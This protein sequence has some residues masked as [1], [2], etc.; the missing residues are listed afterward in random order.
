MT[1][2][3]VDY[4]PHARGVFTPLERMYVER[5][6]KA[7]FVALH[8]LHYK[9]EARPIAPHFYRLM[10]AGENGAEAQ[11]IGVMVLAIPRPL[12]KERHKAFP[13]LKPVS[14]SRLT[15][16]LHYQMINQHFRVVSRLVIDT[17]YRGVGVSY[18]FQNLASRM[19]GFRLLEIQSAMSK[20]NLFAQKA[21]FRFVKPM[22][23]NTYDK[24]VRFFRE[25]FES[26]PADTEALLAEIEAL[27]PPLREHRVK[28]LKTFYYGNSS[29]EKTG[30][31]RDTGAGRVAA[32]STREVL[33]QAQQLV[34]GSPLYGVYQNPDHGRVDIPARL[35]LLDF[36]RQKTSERLKT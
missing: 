28:E 23:S 17:M 29:I 30:A 18:R 32:M 16:T 3:T 36:D 20:Y 15:N 11:L 25:T 22:R 9:S 33:K 14:Q 35:A 19:S 8:H 4:A 13:K 1:E 21:G 12:L 7:D 10:L 24:G 5:G 2:A 31:M 26:H 27:P 34:L 6:S